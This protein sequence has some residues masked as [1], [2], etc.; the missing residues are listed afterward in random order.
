MAAVPTF[1]L[2]HVGVASTSALLDEIGP[3][4]KARSWTRHIWDG[5]VAW[6]A[7]GRGVKKA[8]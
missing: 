4:E 6:S 8:K 2:V 5:T 3:F 7:H 1:C